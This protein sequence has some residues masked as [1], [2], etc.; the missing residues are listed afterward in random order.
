MPKVHSFEVLVVNC[1]ALKVQ[2]PK[3]DDHQTQF[4]NEAHSAVLELMNGASALVGMS[5]VCQKGTVVGSAFMIENTM[6]TV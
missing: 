5:V 1:S 2:Q 3:I 6:L 4:Y